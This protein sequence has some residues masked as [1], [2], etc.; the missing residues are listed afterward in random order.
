MMIEVENHSK[1]HFRAY[2]FQNLPTVKN[3]V[4]IAHQLAVTP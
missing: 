3:V 2:N 4:C 1:Y